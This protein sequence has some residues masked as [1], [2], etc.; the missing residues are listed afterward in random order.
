[1]TTLIPT[2]FDFKPGTK[3]DFQAFAD[4]AP[5]AHFRYESFSIRE[6]APTLVAI[7]TPSLRSLHVYLD[8]MDNKNPGSLYGFMLDESDA[9]FALVIGFDQYIKLIKQIITDALRDE[10]SLINAVAPYGI[11]PL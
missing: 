8:G 1:M 2:H 10:L 6:D 4:A 3:G 5:D 7:Y 11:K 9:S